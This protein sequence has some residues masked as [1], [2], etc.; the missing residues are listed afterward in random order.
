[1]H[2]M[3]DE[4]E[5][6]PIEGGVERLDE[7]VLERLAGRYAYFFGVNEG[8]VLPDGTETESG[9]IIDEQER[10]Y[11]YWTGWN[12]KLDRLEFE[13]WEQIEAEPHWQRSAEYRRARA[14]LR[15]PEVSAQDG[16]PSS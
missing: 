10:V 3:D 13:S 1:M 5:L 14:E 12:V 2:D 7:L 16:D 9:L 6:V 8:H 15:L 4:D 11:A